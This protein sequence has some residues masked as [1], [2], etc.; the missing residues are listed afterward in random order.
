ME[1]IFQC[2]ICLLFSVFLQ[3]YSSLSCYEQYAIVKC[4]TMIISCLWRIG[5]ISCL[6]FTDMVKVDGGI[7]HAS[8]TII[9]K[10]KFVPPPVHLIIS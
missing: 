10:L 4:L 7:C 6:V 2:K 5:C 8:G 1:L 9:T 3:H